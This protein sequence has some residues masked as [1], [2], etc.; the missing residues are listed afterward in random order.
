MVEVAVTVERRG[1][2]CRPGTV[3]RAA[4]KGKSKVPYGEETDDKQLC[5]QVTQAVTGKG[6]HRRGSSQLDGEGR[7]DLKGWIDEGVRAGGGR[8]V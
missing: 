3:L 2:V 7:A 6:E 1:C 4:E 5:L 8:G